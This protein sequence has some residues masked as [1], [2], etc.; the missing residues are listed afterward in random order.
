[1]EI[2]PHKDYDYY[3]MSQK[4]LTRKKT[5]NGV[6]SMTWVDEE[7]VFIINQLIHTYIE[8]IKTMVC[9]GCRSGVEVDMF[10]NLNPTSEIYGTDIY[11]HAYKYDKNFFRDIDF[12]T[13][14]KGWTDYFD[15]IYSNSID[16][17]RDPVNTL[18]AWRTELNDSGVIFV[19]FY[20]GR[21][22]SREDCFH[23]DPLNWKKEIEELSHST[24][25]TINHFSDEYVDR[26]NNHCVD[27]IFRKGN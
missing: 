6:N 12:D 4:S 17:S 1:M 8:N 22:V 16:H 25:L 24:G 26:Y 19:T 3:V 20:W 21:G 11:K 15:V 14:P 23:L 27:V 2:Y 5:N 13:I 10:Q 9:H 18:L 7:K